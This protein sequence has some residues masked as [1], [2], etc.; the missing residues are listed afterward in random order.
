MGRV[1][2]AAVQHVVSKGG[3][4][5]EQ[6]PGSPASAD[7]GPDR[8]KFKTGSSNGTGGTGS[9]SVTGTHSQ[10]VH[11]P[12]GSPS[13]FSTNAGYDFADVM[14]H[15]GHWW[16]PHVIYHA[17]WFDMLVT[18][19]IVL[20]AIQMGIETDHPEHKDL[21]GIIEMIF[22]IIFGFEMFVKKFVLRWSYFRDGWNLLDFFLVWMSIID[23]LLLPL[24][25]GGSSGMQ[26]LSVL[27][28]LRLLRVVKMVRLLKAFKQLWLIV[29]GLL[30]SIKTIFWSALLLLMILYVFGIF[31]C[32]MVGQNTKVGYYRRIDHEPEGTIIDYHPD[33]DVYEHF[34]TMPRAMFTLFET[35]LE[36]LNIRPVVEEQ[37][38]LVPFMLAFI[39]ITTFGVMNVIIGVIVENTTAAAK[40]TDEE[41]HILDF[42]KKI[43]YAEKLRDAIK[44]VDEDN[45]GVLTFEEIAEAFSN[46]E[47]A[48]MST[49]LKFPAGFSDEEFFD[50]LDVDGGGL[51]SDSS[52]LRTLLRSI[53]HDMPQ[54]LTELKISMHRSMS[55]TK[56][57]LLGMKSYQEKCIQPVCGVMDHCISLDNVFDDL[58]AN[59]AAAYARLGGCDPLPPTEA[60]TTHR[61]VLSTLQMDKADGGV[62]AAKKMFRRAATKSVD[63]GD[64]WAKLP[65][66]F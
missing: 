34:G 38:Y 10:S 57:F 46:T 23:T 62:E 59:F 26:S 61:T 8:D 4:H 37:P 56:M 5:A 28:I 22:T 27:R 7:V 48:M 64:G 58:D 52:M 44:A 30:D 20:N 31:F 6:N 16:N 19:S 2:T 66:R 40:A 33:F 39:F 42:Q 63:L 9:H 55:V 49:D 25:L 54:K 45:D 36:P 1:R 21:Y 18:I 43:S 24:I 32:Q 50:F 41:V 65:K 53:V 35:S 17:K 51:V 13:H 15:S 11:S 60:D 47:F 12:R 14:E 29:K 3:H